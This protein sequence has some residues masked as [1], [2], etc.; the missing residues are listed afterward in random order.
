[1]I[2]I[3]SKAKHIVI[4]VS[5]RP[6]NQYFPDQ[7][8]CNVCMC[9]EHASARTA[10][11][12]VL[13]AFKLH[14]KQGDRWIYNGIK[15]LKCSGKCNDW[16]F[17]LID[18]IC[19]YVLGFVF[20]LVQGHMQLYCIFEMPVPCLKCRC[21]NGNYLLIKAFVYTNGVV[22]LIKYHWV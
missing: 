13:R 17:W 10:C 5:M 12:I 9:L 8:S 14:I 6:L 19:R 18:C 4:I 15:V 7:V 11:V 1:M 20:E 3:T 16:L 22:F 2:G 21:Q